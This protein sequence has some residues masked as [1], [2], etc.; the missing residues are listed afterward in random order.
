MEGAILQV[1]APTFVPGGVWADAGETKAT[2]SAINASA[3]QCLNMT[4]FPA[5]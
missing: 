3:K 5:L 4:G 2:A 1:S